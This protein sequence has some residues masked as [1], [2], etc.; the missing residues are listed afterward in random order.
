MLVVLISS[1]RNTS[2]YSTRDAKNTA[3]SRK[4]TFLLA[5]IEQATSF[6]AISIR[7]SLNT[8]FYS[9]EIKE[10]V[11]SIVSLSSRSNII[12][13]TTSEFNSDFLVSNIKIIKEVLPLVK[14]I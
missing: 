2:L 4:Y 13:N 10:L 5:Y 9:K 6:S 11:I 12:V 14:S 8:T 3:L 7:N 1:T